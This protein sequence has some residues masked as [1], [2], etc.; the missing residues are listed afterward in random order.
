MNSEVGMDNLRTYKM[1]KHR[2]EIEKKYLDFFQTE[3]SENL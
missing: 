2:F 3:S 1:I